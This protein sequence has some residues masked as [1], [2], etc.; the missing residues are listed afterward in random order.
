MSKKML[1]S[2]GANAFVLN[3]PIRT[4][5]CLVL[6]W[7]LVRC[8]PMEKIQIG[9]KRWKNRRQYVSMTFE[10]AIIAYAS[11]QKVKRV[12]WLRLACLETS[13]AM[14][15][16][17]YWERKSVDWCIGVKLAP[18]ESHAWIEIH[19]VP[20]DDKEGIESYQKILTI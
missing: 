10:E 20:V 13:L 5:L 8:F 3:K 1:F 15:M 7:V 16:Y 14:V 2:D 18:F 17:A 6:A 9:L 4:C 11:M 19:G 12:L